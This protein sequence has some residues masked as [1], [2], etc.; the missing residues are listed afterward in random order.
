MIVQEF[1][2]KDF[3]PADLYKYCLEYIEKRTYF[4]AKRIAEDFLVEHGF[5]RWKREYLENIKTVTHRFTKVIRKLKAEGII[6]Q[7]T[8]F[9]YI[10]KK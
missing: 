4:K 1:N 10:R 7:Y 9:L 6:E 5:I 2:L 8:R 3:S